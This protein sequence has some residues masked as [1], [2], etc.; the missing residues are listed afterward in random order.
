[1]LHAERTIFGEPA[2]QHVFF[3]QGA[4]EHE[5]DTVL[6]QNRCLALDVGRDQRGAPAKLNQVDVLARTHDDIL[7]QPDWNPVVDYHRQSSGPR[8][9]LA[10]RSR[11]C[12]R[13]P[14]SSPSLAAF[15][16]VPSGMR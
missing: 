3:E 9:G 1:M 11:H 8:L 6:L 4:A 12:M 14:R 2:L 10:N 7:E 16:R 13:N 5:W 15:E